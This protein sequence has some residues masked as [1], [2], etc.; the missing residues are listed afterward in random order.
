MYT[1]LAPSFDTNISANSTPISV[2]LAA[3]ST[4]IGVRKYSYKEKVKEHILCTTDGDFPFP[5]QTHR[6]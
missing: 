3:N 6:Q 1:K 5:K 2:L 4:P